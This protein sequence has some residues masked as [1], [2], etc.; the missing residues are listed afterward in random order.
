MI[1][2]GSGFIGSHLC[3]SLLPD[4][5][6]IVILVRNEKKQ[7]NV[8]HLLNKITIENVDVTDKNR[9]E[10]I[11]DK[12]QP[13]VIFHL[14]GNTSHKHSFDD[15][16][17]DIDVN[18]KS[19]L[20]ILEMI[21]KLGIKCR[22]ILGSTFIV[23]GKNAKLPINE[24]TN[25]NPS[26]IYGANRLLSEIYCKIYNNVYGIDTIVFRITNSY[27]PKEQFETPTK[28]ALNYL[29]YQAYKGKEIS[30]FN[31]GEFFRDIIYVSDVIEGLK[32]IMKNGVSGNIYWIASG[33]KTWFKEIGKL[34]EELTNTNVKYVP[35]P[36]YTDKVD[37]GNF[38]VDNSKLESLGWKPTIS[39]K[40]GIM[41]TLNYFKENNL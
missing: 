5:H 22:F 11:I 28:N 36:E 32:I 12:H 38:L 23:I 2:G 4:K 29:I 7:K 20:I 3:E 15:P 19:T 40:D 25:C 21:R 37:V 39:V 31:K 33:S 17:Y 6:E 10:E 9:L 24:E 35:S 30:I 8:E 34:L 26:T 16:L 1:T 27:G 13:D 18:S 41:K 14:A